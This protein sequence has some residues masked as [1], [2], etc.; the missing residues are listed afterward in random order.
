MRNLIRE[1]QET[2]TGDLTGPLT[3]TYPAALKDGIGAAAW[4][5]FFL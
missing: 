2:Y 5:S 3:L 1:Q 4:V